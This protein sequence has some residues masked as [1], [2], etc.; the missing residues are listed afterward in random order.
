MSDVALTQFKKTLE[1]AEEL[2]LLEQRY[3]HNPP[4]STE[5]KAVQGLRGGVAVFVVAAFENYLKNL[6]EEHLSELSF[7]HKS[8]SLNKLPDHLQVN[9]VYRLLDHA[10]K[11]PAFQ[12]APPK[13]QRIQDIE[14]ACKII[15]SGDIDPIVFCDVSSNPNS[16]NVKSLFSNVAINDIFITIKSKFDRKWRSPTAQTFIEDKLD[17]IV[18]RRHLVAHTADALAI[19]RSDLKASIRFLKILATL[20]DS[21]M[22]DH[23]AKLIKQCT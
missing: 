20:L 19:T 16:K 18:N 21:E 22:R 6:M 2:L 17:E 1:I 4:R 15:I 13:T 11:G 3:F 12:T 8:L 23:T 10:M 9:R 5:Q 7:K 14:R